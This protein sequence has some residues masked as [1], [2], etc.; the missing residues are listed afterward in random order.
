[1]FQEL[2]MHAPSPKGKGLGMRGLSLPTH[3]LS[4]SLNV[5]IFIFI[6]VN[7]KRVYN[8]GASKQIFDNAKTLRKK[9]TEAED[10]LWQMLRNRKV[11]G[12]K[13]RRQH[14]MSC[15]IA[16]FYCH[17]A[18]L[19]IE[20]DGDIHDLETIKLYDKQREEKITELGITVLRFT[21]EAI[22]SEPDAVIKKIELYLKN[23][24]A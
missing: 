16:D 10:R 4:F 9:S 7:S 5:F 11:A 20:A 21:N 1:M 12:F 17:E 23:Y 3:N 14:P 6:S 8:Y 18:L 2:T 15:F 19:V 13:F 22:F 24:N